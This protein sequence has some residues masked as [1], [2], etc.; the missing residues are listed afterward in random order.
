MEFAELVNDVFVLLP[1]D[2]MARKQTMMS[3]ANMT[4]YSTAVGPSSRAT[5]CR[6]RCTKLRMAFSFELFG[7]A[8]GRTSPKRSPSAD[9]CHGDW[10][11]GGNDSAFSIRRAVPLHVPTQ[12][13]RAPA[14][15]TSSSV[16][17]Q[18]PSLRTPGLSVL[19]EPAPPNCVALPARSFQTTETDRCN[20]NRSIQ[21]GERHR[22]LA[23]HDARCRAL[24]AR[25]ATSTCW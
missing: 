25:L 10:N 12:P 21:R 4:A 11:V 7:R 19:R 9:A 15:R 16:L 23:N 18:K 20:P 13:G 6:T 8:V 14:D 3:S 24:T 17:L 5:K 22:R 2:R 1:T